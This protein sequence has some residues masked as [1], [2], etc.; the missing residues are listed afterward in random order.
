MLFFG[1]YLRHFISKPKIEQWRFYLYIKNYILTLLLIAG[2]KR[3]QMHF[4]TA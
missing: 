3:L 4:K 2:S 1:N